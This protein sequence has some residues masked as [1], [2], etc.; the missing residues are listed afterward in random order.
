MNSSI[1]AEASNSLNYIRWTECLLNFGLFVCIVSSNCTLLVLLQNRL[2]SNPI[3]TINIFRK[4]ILVIQRFVDLIS[5]IAFFSSILISLFIPKVCGIFEVFCQYC[6]ACSMVLMCLECWERCFAIV[7]PLSYRA[8]MTV[9][10]TLRL[11]GIC[12]GILLL[13]YIIAGALSVERNTKLTG[14]DNEDILF[15]NGLKNRGVFNLLTGLIELFLTSFS[16]F[17]CSFFIYKKLQASLHNGP[18]RSASIWNH[19]SANVPVDTYESKVNRWLESNGLPSGIEEHVDVHIVYVL[20]RELHS[21]GLS[22]QVSPLDS[23]PEITCPNETQKTIEQDES[24]IEQDVR[25]PMLLHPYYS[26]SSKSTLDTDSKSINDDKSDILPVQTLLPSPQHNINVSYT[27]LIPKK[28][29]ISTSNKRS[30]SMSE[31]RRQC[32][33]IHGNRSLSCSN[34]NND[35][36][37]FNASTIQEMPKLKSISVV[38]PSII[39]SPVN[40]SPE[41]YSLHH[42]MRKKSEIS[43]SYSIQP[44][45][46]SEANSF[47]VVNIKSTN[48]KRRTLDLC[49]NKIALSTWFGKRITNEFSIIMSD[50]NVMKIGKHL[51]QQRTLAIL[52]NLIYGSLILV[53]LQ[54]PFSL[55]KILIYFNCSF[56][57]SQSSVFRLAKLIKVAQ[58]FVLPVFFTF[59]NKTLNRYIKRKI[60]SIKNFW[61]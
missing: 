16:T 32:I 59:S 25:E 39:G 1:L 29:S 42:D 8:H 19:R 44:F 2:F 61:T 13:V 53:G 45:R 30:S 10:K 5:G 4:Y 40:V 33:N 52:H 28:S 37:L 11:I 50:E 14:N 41:D 20:A 46:G 3:N 22:C 38:V 31:I 27:T 34:L 15:I 57:I 21:G 26:V 51:H 12:M 48:L 54:L 47:S 36:V 58:C 56:Y 60:Q 7:S 35:L 18:D 43:S 23:A 17:T 49:G 9:Y 55:C 6:L 24:T